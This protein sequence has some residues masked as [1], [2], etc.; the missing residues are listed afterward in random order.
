[1]IGFDK[2]VCK[3]AIRLSGFYW[4]RV[5]NATTYHIPIVSCVFLCR[6]P[7]LWFTSKTSTTQLVQTCYL[8]L[9]SC[10]LLVWN[11]SVL[12]IGIQE[13]SQKCLFFICQIITEPHSW[14]TRDP[15]S[16]WNSFNQRL[17]FVWTKC[18]VFC[19]NIYLLAS[20]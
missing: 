5:F 16:D 1:M 8:I 6:N 12:K 4:K 15:D 20:F 18:F 11:V 3:V 17:T 9:R 2:N 13:I 7:H 14:N 19:W 10:F